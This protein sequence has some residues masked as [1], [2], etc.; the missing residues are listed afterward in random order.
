DHATPI[1]PAEWICSGV[2]IDQPIPTSL[3]ARLL[4]QRDL[5]LYPELPRTRTPRT[6]NR[7]LIGYVTRDPEVIT[8]AKALPQHITRYEHPMIC[9]ARWI[10]AGHTSHD[11]AH[12]IITGMVFP[13]KHDISPAH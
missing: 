10:H 9:L 4:A 7:Q 6:L 8:L 3:A 13:G 1:R 12:K 5:L 2:P 11:A